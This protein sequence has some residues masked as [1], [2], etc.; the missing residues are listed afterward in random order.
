MAKKA[1]LE[2]LES[3]I[4]KY[5]HN[6][7]SES[8]NVAVWSGKIELQSLQLDVH[9]V[10]S[11][12]SRRAILAPNLACP[13]KVIEG[14]FDKV[15]L[16]VPWARLTS[17]PVVFRASGLWVYV[18]P[19]DFI[20]EARIN[21]NGYTENRYGTKMKSRKSVMQQQQQQQQQKV[22]GSKEGVMEERINSIATAE[23]GRRRMSAMKNFALGGGGQD[24]GDNEDSED[25][26]DTN[27]TSNSSSSNTFTTRLVRRI[28]E[29]LQ[30]EIQDVHIAIRGC[31]TA[32]GIVLGSLSL[33]TT[34]A[35]GN[36]TFVDRSSASSSSASAMNHHEQVTL[37]FL[38]KELLISGFGIYLQRDNDDTNS[39]GGTLKQRLARVSTNTE[40]ILEPLS[41]QA[42]LRQ[43]DLDT[44]IDFPKYLVHSK[45]SSLSITVSRNQLELG[46]Q[47]AMAVV[48]SQ[49]NSTTTENRPLFPE[50]RPLVPVKG[51]AHK[52]WK[53]AVRCI[54][55]LN[56]H[57]SWIEFYLAFQKRKRYLELHKRNVYSERRD[58]KGVVTSSPWLSKLRIE[59]RVELENIERDRSISIL[60]LMHWRNIAD[61][62][63]VK[64]KEKYHRIGTVSGSSG[65]SSISSNA[66]KKKSSKKSSSF[67]KTKSSVFGSP[68]KR[69]S[70]SLS[71]QDS[72][73]T[74]ELY[75]ELTDDGNNDDDEDDIALTTDEMR[76]LEKNL[77]MTTIDSTLSKDS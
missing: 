64:E 13:F 50:Y 60:G 10:N 38:Y 49:P 45:L 29:N 42:K 75:Q 70:S 69:T 21:P 59:E 47:L 32:A 40:Y 54:G 36:K 56:R 15:Q 37:S 41:F 53:Y 9:A 61:A 1:I 24:D 39:N 76:E 33:S 19:H 30:V 27:T 48:T 73:G 22:Q 23:E 62:Q 14:R 17:R 52:W 55:R 11:E 5:V 7:D 28:I 51:N 65:G 46:H 43:S 74:S 72:L 6:L 68:A 63:F 34:D 77:A 67:A 44:C 26:S 25:V 20:A 12:L 57:R 35:K 71:Q 18:E 3:T 58:K 8:L 2:V 31:Q 4:G 16:D 66:G